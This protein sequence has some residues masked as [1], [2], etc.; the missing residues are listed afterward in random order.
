MET[1]KNLKQEITFLYWS[2]F[3]FHSCLSQTVKMTEVGRVLCVHLF[4]PQLQQGHPDQGAQTYIQVAFGDLQGKV[5]TAFLGILCPATR[6]VKECWYLNML[7]RRCMTLH[8]LLNTVRLLPAHLSSLLR[9]L[10]M[11]VQ[12]S[13]ISTSSPGFGTS[14]SEA[15][16]SLW[17]DLFITSQFFQF[18]HTYLEQVNSQ[19]AI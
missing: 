14:L 18:F 3:S 7:L 4:Q 15:F 11:A 17:Y 8:F 19:T 2:D 5:S 9:S 16:L 6:M 13:G 12:P 1:Q 10:W